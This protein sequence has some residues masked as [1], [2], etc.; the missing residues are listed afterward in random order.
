[1]SPEK[2]KYCDKSH[3]DDCPHFTMKA[4]LRAMLILCDTSINKN[5][6]SLSHLVVSTTSVS[7]RKTP[8]VCW[9]AMAEYHRQN[10]VNSRIYAL[11]SGDW[12]S[13][14][15]VSALFF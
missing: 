7:P 9:A 3:E 12:K 6:H 8:T 1:M 5:C 13:E 2:T 11:W 4:G 10:G 14:I 15:E